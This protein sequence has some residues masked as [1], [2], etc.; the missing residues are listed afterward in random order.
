MIKNTREI[1][2][3]ESTQKLNKTESI[4]VLFTVNTNT[5][6]F[7]RPISNQKAGNMITCSLY[8]DLSTTL[9]CSD[10]GCF[11]DYQLGYCNLAEYQRV[12]SMQSCLSSS[13]TCYSDSM[14]SSQHVHCCQVWDWMQCRI[15]LDKQQNTQHKMQQ[16]TELV[17][18][19]FQSITLTYGVIT[20][21][22]L[23]V[24]VLHSQ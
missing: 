3:L 10:V 15:T 7:R 24:S 16:P 11:A 8:S 5:L 1:I 19:P 14:V 2:F 17:S 20:K 6:Q 22:Y 18:I 13:L 9:T 12:R 21:L 4:N 23:D